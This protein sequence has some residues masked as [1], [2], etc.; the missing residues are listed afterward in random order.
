MITDCLSKFRGLRILV[1]GDV[2]ADHYIRGKVS[3]LSPEAPVPILHVQEDQWLPGGAA[4]VAKNIT[5]LGARAELVGL[6]GDDEAGER[7]RAMLAQDKLLKPTMIVEKRMPTI[8]KTRCIA[9]GQQMLRLDREVVGAASPATMAKAQARITTLMDTCDGIIL[10]DYGKGFLEPDFIQ[11]IIAAARKKAKRVFVDPKGHDYARY[12]GATAMTPNQ[13][14]AAQASKTPINDVES[15]TQAARILLKQVGCEILVI[16][17]GP[18]GV[19]VFPKRGKSILLP[20]KAREV[21]DVTGAGDTFISLFSLGLCAGASLEDAAA[22]GN[23]AGG[24]V[25]ARHGVATISQDELRAAAQ[26]D[27]H[28]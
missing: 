27:T 2:I 25:V 1:I 21:F 9:Q 26:E 8:L 19:S 6:I 11:R 12:R 17:R 23:L 14:E 7:V 22:L 4:N 3:R 20:A 13:G 16:T 24:A 15:L 28:A 5:A 18:Q 10:S